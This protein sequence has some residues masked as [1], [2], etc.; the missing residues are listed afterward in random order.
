MAAV[1]P[2][3]GIL[4]PP[5]RATVTVMSFLVAPL[6]KTW[7]ALPSKALEMV[8]GKQM[9]EA[10]EISREAPELRDRYGRAAFGQRSPARTSGNAAIV[11]I[12]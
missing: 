1:S 3:V 10:F 4:W 2:W 11:P 5:W 12:S 9:R 8:S 7:V 6:R